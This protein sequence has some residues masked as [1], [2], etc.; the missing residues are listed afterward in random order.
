M[1]ILTS[2]SYPAI[3]Q[4]LHV[5]LTPESLPDAMISLDIYMGAAEA[6]V[7]RRD[8]L[9]ASRTGAELLHIKNAIIFLVAAYLAPAIEM[10]LSESIPGGGY[11]YQR[12]EVNWKDRAESLMA[13][14]ESEL[15]AVLAP[16]GSD[17]ARSSSARPTFFGVASRVYTNG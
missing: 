14:Y 16:V 11:R 7:V 2:T 8:P 4:A 13:R 17:E 3:R 1:A 5:S 12:P 6:E 10:V 15:A 9:A